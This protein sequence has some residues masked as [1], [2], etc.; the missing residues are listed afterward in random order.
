MELSVQ[1]FNDI[2]RRWQL[3][4]LRN[5]QR[6]LGF[7]SRTLDKLCHPQVGKA[8][9]SDTSLRLLGTLWHY[10]DQIFLDE[11]LALERDDLQQK[12]MQLVQVIYPPPRA[13]TRYDNDRH[14][15]G[16]PDSRQG[17]GRHSYRL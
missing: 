5:M 7:D 13:I 3:G 9:T 6:E 17:A 16:T 4:S 10:A 15:P 1:W 8:I 12:L 2:R 14:G 11:Q